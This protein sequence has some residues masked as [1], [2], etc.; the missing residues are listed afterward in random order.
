MKSTTRFR[1]KQPLKRGRHVLRPKQPQR[2]ASGAKGG[3]AAR[4]SQRLRRSERLR[5]DGSSRINPEPS[6]G[7]TRQQQLRDG[8]TS[9]PTTDPLFFQTSGMAT[10]RHGSSSSP[11][12]AGGT[13]SHSNLSSRLQHD[14]HGT[15][16]GSPGPYYTDYY[17]NG[18]LPSI[19]ENRPYPLSS[20]AVTA[21]T[22]DQAVKIEHTNDIY[23]TASPSPPNHWSHL[24]KHDPNNPLFSFQSTGLAFDNTPGGTP[25][26]TPDGTPEPKTPGIIGNTMVP[27][28]EDLTN[29]EYHT[30]GIHYDMH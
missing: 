18:A 19:P 16:R 15:H 7:L 21:G 23:A 4:K 11:S 25:N 29:D 13:F 14:I 10:G 24:M 22:S 1:P 3:Q 6:A 20:Q 8:I 9:Y 26:G 27:D 30:M 2:Q 28:F 5:Q 12:G 17:G